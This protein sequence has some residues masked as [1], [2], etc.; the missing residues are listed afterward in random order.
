MV[1]ARWGEGGSALLSG[2]NGDVQPDR[3]YGF[4]RGFCLERYIDF[5]TFCLNRG[6]VTETALSDFTKL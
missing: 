6:I 1:R 3:V 4:F 2:I 5:I